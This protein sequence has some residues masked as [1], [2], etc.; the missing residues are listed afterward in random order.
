MID[1]TLDSFVFGGFLNDNKAGALIVDVL[2]L[3]DNKADGLTVI[4]LFLNDNKAGAL[5]VDVL[6]LN[7]NMAGALIVIYWNCMLADSGLKLCSSCI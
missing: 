1:S 4:V 2:F 7:D 6:F 3:N 5:T